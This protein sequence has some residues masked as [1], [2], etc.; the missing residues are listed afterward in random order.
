[1]TTLTARVLG[2]AVAL[3]LVLGLAGCGDDG[4]DSHRSVDAADIAAAPRTSGVDD[5]CE[6]WND[7]MGVSADASP[8]KLADGL[9]DGAE[10]LT[11][12][13]TPEELSDAER[14]GF[15]AFVAAMADID[16]DGVEQFQRAAGPD[17]LAD[18]FGLDADQGKDVVA[19]LDYAATACV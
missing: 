19:F 9:Q 16:A 13:G 5:F 8:D 3:P 17:D 18:A 7:D 14:D 12:V 11:Q 10:R 4:H 6:A 1:M 15:E 2:A